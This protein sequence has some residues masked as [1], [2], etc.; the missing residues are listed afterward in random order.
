MGDRHSGDEGFDDVV[1][2]PGVGGGLQDEGVGGL[3]V[4]GGPFREARDRDSTG[5]KDSLFPGVDGSGDDV[6]LVDVESDEALNG[7]RHGLTPF[8]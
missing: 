6:M 8:W 2:V 4:L 5:M 1:D 3:E 7:C